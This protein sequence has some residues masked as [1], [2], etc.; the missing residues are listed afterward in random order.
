MSNQYCVLTQLKITSLAQ[1]KALYA[2][3]AREYTPY[4]CNPDLSSL[5]ESMMPQRHYNDIFRDLI[6]AKGI[7]VRKDAV[8]ALEYTSKFT[9]GT[10]LDLDQW[11]EQNRKFFEDT[12]GK[13]NVVSMIVHYDEHSPHIHTLVIPMVKRTKTYKDGHTKDYYS[14]SAKSF[15]GG[16][17]AMKKLQASYAEYMK[18]FGLKKGKKTKKDKASYEDISTFYKEIKHSANLT[19]PKPTDTETIDEYICRVTPALREESMNYQRLIRKWKKEAHEKEILLEEYA[20][21][22]KWAESLKDT[23]VIKTLMALPKEDLISL[24][25]SLKSDQYVSKRQGDQHVVNN[26]P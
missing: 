11:K 25:N 26:M 1:M 17:I 20:A 8:L 21:I 22:I 3:N 23:S 9:P 18:P 12:F 14:L 13:E 5:N 7:K 15:T 6:A 10:R 4:N 16:T 24:A 2:H 19:L